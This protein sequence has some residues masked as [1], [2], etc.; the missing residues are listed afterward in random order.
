MTWLGAPR[1]PKKLYRGGKVSVAAFERLKAATGQVIA[2]TTFAS[3]SER[4]EKARR[5]PRIPPKAWQGAVLFEFE[6]IARHRIGGFAAREMQGEEETLIQPF[7]PVFL[8]EV[9]ELA[10]RPLFVIK[11][12]RVARPPPPTAQLVFALPQMEASLSVTLQVIGGGSK[13]KR[14]VDSAATVDDVLRAASEGFGMEMEAVLDD[15]CDLHGSF[16]AELC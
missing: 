16:R 11:N 4:L 8:A 15:E 3:F 2:F 7:A 6:S 9:G 5:F 12:L 13:M 10:D 14:V 1:E